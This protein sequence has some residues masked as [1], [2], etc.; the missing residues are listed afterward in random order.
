MLSP[1]AAYIAK[2]TLLGAACQ[3]EGSCLQFV[4]HVSRKLWDGSVDVGTKT[5]LLGRSKFAG[6]NGLELMAKVESETD[7]FDAVIVKNQTAQENTDHWGVP[8]MTFQ[9]RN[10]LWARSYRNI[11]MENAPRRLAKKIGYS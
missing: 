7:K 2:I 6:L 9:R 3:I 1:R 5:T 10:I 11:I 8:L 4:D